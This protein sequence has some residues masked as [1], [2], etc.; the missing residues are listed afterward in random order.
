MKQ[1]RVW[2]RAAI[3]LLALAGVTQA[4]RADEMSTIKSRGSLIVGV[5][6][7]YPPFGY[8]AP[9]GGIIGIE[10]D[11]AA[12]VAKRLGVKVDYVPV[13]ASNRMQFLEQGKIDLMIATMNVTPER[14]KVVWFITP[15]YYASG[16]DVMLPKKLKVSQWSDL[17]DQ[18]IC[19]IQGAY[20]NKDVQEKYGARVIA[21]TGTAEAL[22]AMKQGRCIGFLFDNTAI[23]GQLLSG[24]WNGY[25]MPLKVQ[26]AKPWGMATRFGD[27]DFHDFMDKVSA[28]WAKSGTLLKLDQQYHIQPSEYVKDLQK[29]YAGS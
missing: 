6:A 7:D 24:Q 20:Y 9:S 22:T 2:R 29:K 5:K 26:D 16:Y 18:P 17:K 11:L 13:N 1:M 8:R 4:A 28:D 10:P 21:F 14:E 12:D 3:G 15:Y 19:G 25:G 23:E 27:K